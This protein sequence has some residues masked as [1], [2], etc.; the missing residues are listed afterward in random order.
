VSSLVWQRSR[1]AGPADVVPAAVEVLPAGAVV[2]PELVSAVVP[3]LL[4]L[5]ELLEVLDEWEELRWASVTDPR[6]EQA[7]TASTGRRAAATRT[8]FEVMASR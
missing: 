1:P 2:A 6:K 3:A 5:S 7:Q 8:C 4:E